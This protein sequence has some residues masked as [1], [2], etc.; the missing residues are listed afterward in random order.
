MLDIEIKDNGLAQALADAGYNVAPAIEKALDVAA[1]RA[2]D[3]KSKEVAK[4]Y[5]RPIPRNGKGNPKWRRSGDWARDQVILRDPGMRTVGPLGNSEDYEE[6]L[7]TLPTGPDGVNRTN[8]AAER[9]YDV[10]EQQ[11]AAIFE[12]ELL[13]ALGF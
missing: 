4:T 5:A 10:T 12:Q 6:R 11:V 3:A 13:N 1:K 7:A 2:L 9:A 8:P